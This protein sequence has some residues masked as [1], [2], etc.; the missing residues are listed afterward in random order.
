M[1]TGLKR[2][3]NRCT[4]GVLTGT[5]MLI[6]KRCLRGRWCSFKHHSPKL[7]CMIPVHMQA[8]LLRIKFVC[9]HERQFRIFFGTRRNVK[10]VSLAPYFSPLPLAP[11]RPEPL[12]LA[13]VD[14]DEGR[15]CPRGCITACK[16][17]RLGAFHPG[18]E[19]C[20]SD[21]LA[22][23]FVAKSWKTLQTF[24]A[25]TGA[26]RTSFRSFV[27]RG[28]QETG[29]LHPRSTGLGFHETS[30]PIAFLSA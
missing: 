14:K 20:G 23:T 1:Y 29:L 2:S 3:R 12:S 17:R 10:L 18:A 19:P 8:R 15:V 16:F 28:Q 5:R 11:S 4:S 25:E 27:G 7:S 6:G 22:R 24:V 13:S 26:S 9:K 21:A 30:S